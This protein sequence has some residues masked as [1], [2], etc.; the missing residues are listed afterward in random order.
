MTARDFSTPE[1]DGLAGKCREVSLGKGSRVLIIS[2]PTPPAVLASTLLCRS[3]VNAGGVFHV[4]FVEPMMNAETLASFMSTSLGRTVLVVGVDVSGDLAHDTDSPLPVLI[5][6]TINTGSSSMLSVGK[7]EQV[8]VGAYAIAREKLE[9]GPEEL[10]LATA[11]LLVQDQ[12]QTESDSLSRE[13]ILFAQEADVL[14]ERRGFRVFGTNFLPLIET[15]SNSISPYLRGMSGSIESCE[16]VLSEA[17]IPPSR[18]SMPITSLAGEEMR[19]LTEKLAVKLDIS[20]IRRLLGLDFEN[21]LEPESGPLR[22]LSAIKSMSE[23]AWCRHET[24]LAMAVWM[25][26]HARML[27]MLLDSYRLHCR[28]TISGVQR[29]LSAQSNQEV[30]VQSDSIAVAP[31]S[32]APR[33]VLPDVCRIV[34]EN[35]YADR[36]QFLVLEREDCA[37]VAWDFEDMR[38]HNIL[39]S[40]TMAG[41]SSSS[42]SPRSVLVHMTKEKREDLFDAIRGLAGEMR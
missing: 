31:M 2:S 17:D 19:R 42:A 29:F 28:E 39:Q 5:G 16:R 6:S 25:G 38:L 21:H 3:I 23:V 7:R 22:F 11:G 36:E 30:A 15:L 18:H 24:G 9:V 8:S 35:G 4:T 26:D 12:L 37:C 20:V 1:L 14:A 40:F 41:L 27:R 34:F 10:Y 33:E 32:G 13:M